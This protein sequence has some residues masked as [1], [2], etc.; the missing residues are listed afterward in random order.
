MRFEV[1]WGRDAPLHESLDGKVNVLCPVLANNEERIDRCG[2]YRCG[3]G[4]QGFECFGSYENKIKSLH[5]CHGEN[6]NEF[7]ERVDALATEFLGFEK[8]MMERYVI[9]CW[10]RSFR[11]LF[12]IFSIR[13]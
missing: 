9:Q 10:V 12:S 7:V 5:A 13:H 4:R 11:L 3:P 6:G 2:H 1:L 8:G